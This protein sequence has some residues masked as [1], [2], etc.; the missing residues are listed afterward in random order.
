LWESGGITA[1]I[2]NIAPDKGKW[3]AARPGRFNPIVQTPIVKQDAVERRKSLAP[4]GNRT[5][6]F[7]VVQSL[8]YSVY[9]QSYPDN[10]YVILIENLIYLVAINSRY[11]VEL[12]PVSGVLL[13][14]VQNTMDALIGAQSTRIQNIKRGIQKK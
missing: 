8:A 12:I 7:A 5:L 10:N 4:A 14:V 2:L 1:S 3:S 13:L 6:S 11:E 9:R